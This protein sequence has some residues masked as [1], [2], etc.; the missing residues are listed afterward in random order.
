MDE[1]NQICARAIARDFSGNPI[2]HINPPESYTVAYAPIYANRYLTY[3]E[4]QELRDNP[5]YYAEHFRNKNYENE[6]EL[7]E[8]QCLVGILEDNVKNIERKSQK[9]LNDYIEE[10]IK[11]DILIEFITEKFDGCPNEVLGVDMECAFCSHT[12]PFTKKA[13]WKAYFERKMKYDEQI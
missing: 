5:M 7:K 4:E 13:C 2:L 3:N 11:N 12:Q 6:K 9:N 10:K 8:M 1:E